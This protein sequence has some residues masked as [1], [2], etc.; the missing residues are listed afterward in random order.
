MIALQIDARESLSTLQALS[1]DLQ[2]KGVVAAL[3]AG[4]VPALNALKANAPDDSK[5]GG[6][7]IQAAINKTQVK[8]SA[9]LQTSNGKRVINLPDD[10]FALVIGPNKKVGKRAVGWLAHILEVGA[11]AHKIERVI[12]HTTKTYIKGGA[13]YKKTV[14]KFKRP[15][16]INGNF[17]W[18]E[19]SHPGFG[20]KRWIEKAMASSESQ[21]EE[22]VYRGLDKWI[23]KN[24]R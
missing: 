5:T 14:T 23:A 3:H 2:K 13:D 16:K 22:N 12:K 19:V 6:S 9:V 20:Q 11:K 7:R 24:G 8:G 1:A 18:G 15:M 21:I 17:V 4:A 10:T